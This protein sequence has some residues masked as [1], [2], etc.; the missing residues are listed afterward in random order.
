MAENMNDKGHVRKPY[1]GN[2]EI[3][4]FGKLEK[5]EKA[6]AGKV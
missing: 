6:G 3:S 4:K 5:E 2:E 1:F